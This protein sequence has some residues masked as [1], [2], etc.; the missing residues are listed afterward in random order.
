[1]QWC[2]LYIVSITPV[3]TL[4]HASAM[5]SPDLV[6]FCFLYDMIIHNV[7]SKSDSIYYIRIK[8]I[9]AK[10]DKSTHVHHTKFNKSHDVARKPCDTPCFSNVQ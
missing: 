3:S 1:M 10:T 9:S 2:K 6:K 7:C 4:I 5:A 8:Q